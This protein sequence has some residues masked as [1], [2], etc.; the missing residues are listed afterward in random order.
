MDSAQVTSTVLAAWNAAPSGDARKDSGEPLPNAEILQAFF[1]TAFEASL[2]REENRPLT[3]RLMLRSADRFP[4][5]AGP[6]GGLHRLVFHQPRPFTAQE[7]RR[8]TPAVDYDRSLV[9]VLLEEN[10][11]LRIWGIVQSGPRWLE[12]FYGGRGSV[13]NLPD[14]LIVGVRHPGYIIIS[15]GSR[16]LCALEAGALQSNRLNVFNSEWL[17]ESFLTVRNELMQLHAH[18][19]AERDARWANIDPDLT[20]MVAQ[21]MIQRLISTIQRSRHGGTLLIVPTERADEL[22]QAN[23]WVRLKYTFRDEEPRA[24]VRTLFVH[25]MNT[26]A[27]SGAS[28]HSGTSSVGWDEYSHAGD[29][30][31]GN[32]NEA[33][34]EIAHLIA[35]LTAVDGAVIVTK[36]FELLGFGGEI[37]GSLA[38]VPFVARASDLEGATFTIESTEDV[39]TRHRSVYRLCNV[40]QDVLGVVVSQDGGARFVRWKDRQVMYWS[41]STI[42]PR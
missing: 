36:R 32:L 9:G 27:E 34:F 11:E 1:A 13:L 39:G 35:T 38:E 41:H 42:A 23:A 17:S 3:F 25:A 5:L 7:L 14:C 19:R 29:R 2:L 26:L 37:A 20:Q 10:G 16:P 21:Q 12:Q 30:N 15:R 22:I 28:L 40:L 33:I 4:E 8:L 18:A 24:R 31:L 6:P